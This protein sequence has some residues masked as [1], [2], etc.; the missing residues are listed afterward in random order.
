M[1]TLE[2]IKTRATHMCIVQN[3]FSK[4]VIHYYAAVNWFTG[5]VYI[6]MMTGTIGSKQN[7]E[8]AEVFMVSTAYTAQ[9]HTHACL[10]S[11][12]KAWFKNQSPAK[13][14]MASR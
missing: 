6:K 11:H 7:Q 5:A 3:K 4:Y 13:G 9:A 14:S 10:C 8:E 12:I 2:H 1:S